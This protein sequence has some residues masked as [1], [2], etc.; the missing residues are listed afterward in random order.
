MDT[1]EI[2]DFVDGKWLIKSNMDFFSPA[3]SL[4]REEGT[5]RKHREMASL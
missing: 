4:E 3:L 2:L 5:H 1:S